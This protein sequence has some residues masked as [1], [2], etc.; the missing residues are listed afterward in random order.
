LAITGLLFIFCG[1]VCWKLG[2]G[3]QSERTISSRWIIDWPL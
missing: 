2:M 3:S 1:F